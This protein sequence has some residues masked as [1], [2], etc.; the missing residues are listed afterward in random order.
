MALDTIVYA[1]LMTLKA[2]VVTLR[3]LLCKD[4]TMLGGVRL[5]GV[6][7]MKSNCDLLTEVNIGKEG[8]IY[9]QLVLKCLQFS[10]LANS[11]L[12]CYTPQ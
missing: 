12:R 8:G 5:R 7:L 6:R 11:K 10:C 4:C 2:A 9:L 3:A 1:L